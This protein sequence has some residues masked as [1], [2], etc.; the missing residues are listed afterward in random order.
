MMRTIAGTA[1]AGVGLFPSTGN[2]RYLRGY[3]SGSSIVWASPVDVGAARLGSQ[4]HAT[5]DQGGYHWVGGIDGSTGVWA[6]RSASADDGS[7]G[8]VPSFGTTLTLTDSGVAAGNIFALVPISSNRVLAIWRNGSVLKAAELTNAGFGTAAQVNSTTNSHADDWGAAFDGTYV[9]VV[10]SDSTTVGGTWRTRAYN[11][12]TNTWAN[13]TDPSITGQNS[14][15]DGLVVSALSTGGIAAI[16]TDVGSEGGQDRTI[17]A[18]T[19]SGGLSGTWSAKTTIT[20]AGGRGNGDDIAG[21]HVSAN[22]QLPI[23]YLHGDCDTNGIPFTYEYHVLA[24]TDTGVTKTSGAV[25]MSAT[26][27]ASAQRTK[28]QHRVTTMD[29]TATMTATAQR[30]TVAKTSGTVTMSATATLTPVVRK[31]QVRGATLSAVGSVTASAVKIVTN[32]IKTS[33]SV[34]L[35]GTSSLAA[36]AIKKPQFTLS[37]SF[38]MS[39]TSLL[40]IA[41]QHITTFIPKLPD[42]VRWKVLVDPRRRLHACVKELEKSKA[43]FRVFDILL[44]KIDKPNIRTGQLVAYAYSKNM[45]TSTPINLTVQLVEGTD[46]CVSTWT[47]N[48]INVAST[49]AIQVLTKDQIRSLKDYANLKLRFIVSKE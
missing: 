33:G 30:I 10:H 49:D 2:M 19:Y 15:A 27:T 21:P 22:N 46:T 12:S 17:Q 36:N 37:G 32:A 3:V 14:N 6:K 9:F 26:A 16:G 7:T 5:I 42:D 41:V 8:H 34:V 40:Q 47:H 20:P 28:I 4:C 39:A 25:T 1:V 29:A 44:G 11:V 48:N 38:N 23:L 24:T 35:S 45:Q 13:A 43:G 18:K 31:I